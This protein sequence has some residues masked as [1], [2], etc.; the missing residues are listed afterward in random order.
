MGQSQSAT[1][2]SHQVQDFYSNYIQQQQLLIQQQQ[3]QINN[4]YRLNISSHHMDCL[5]LNFVIQDYSVMKILS[6]HCFQHDF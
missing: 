6:Y 4:L 2:N 5:D 1:K 3:L